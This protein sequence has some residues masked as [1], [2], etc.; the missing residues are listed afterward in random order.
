MIFQ[1]LTPVTLSILTC[2]MRPEWLHVPLVPPLPAKMTRSLEPDL[3]PF[4]GRQLE[5]IFM[6]MDKID[7]L[8]IDSHFYTLRCC[9]IAMKILKTNEYSAPSNLFDKLLIEALG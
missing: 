9:C 5:F 8:I 2:G 6:V 3:W 7:C 4:M 1:P